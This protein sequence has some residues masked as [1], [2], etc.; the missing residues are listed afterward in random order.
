MLSYLKLK[1]Y[2]LPVYDMRKTEKPIECMSNAKAGEELIALKSNQ[3]VEGIHLSALYN[4]NYN[5][6]I[7]INLIPKLI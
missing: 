7:C 6:F 1:S 3:L 4:Q 2:S 5:V